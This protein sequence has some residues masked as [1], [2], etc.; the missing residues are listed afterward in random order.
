MIFHCPWRCCRFFDKEI[1]CLALI[2]TSSQTRLRL[3]PGLAFAQHFAYG[4]NGD[5]N[6]TQALLC[7]SR[8]A[9]LTILCF[10]RS[11]WTAMRLPAEFSNGLHGLLSF[12]FGR[13]AVVVEQ[14]R[15][16]PCGKIA[17]GQ[18]ANRFLGATATSTNF[19]IQ[20]IAGMADSWKIEDRPQ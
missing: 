9:A 17:T 11:P 20:V 16:A 18:S 13:W 14:Q 4:V 15:L 6:A 8:R 10:V 3:F 5:I 12:L 7:S 19:L 2:S 1:G